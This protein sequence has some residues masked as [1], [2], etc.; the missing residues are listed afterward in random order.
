M[1]EA[2]AGEAVRARLRV[3]RDSAYVRDRAGALRSSS[4]S[5]VYGTRHRMELAVV[6]GMPVPSTAAAVVAPDH[7][8]Q[9]EAAAV[10]TVRSLRAIQCKR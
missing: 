5:A 4:S 7:T 6:E 2:V 10:N 1:V 3:T 8:A 9:A